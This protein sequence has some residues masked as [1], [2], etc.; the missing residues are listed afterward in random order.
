[1]VMVGIGHTAFPDGGAAIATGA[2]P[3]VGTKYLG[4]VFSQIRQ[5]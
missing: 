4:A 2:R 3:A 5:R 1:M